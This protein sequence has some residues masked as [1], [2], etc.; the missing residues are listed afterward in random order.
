MSDASPANHFHAKAI[1]DPT[2][3]SL[4]LAQ[5]RNFF[6]ATVSVLHNSSTTYRGKPLNGLAS[7]RA[8]RNLIAFCPA[9]ILVVIYPLVYH[10][11]GL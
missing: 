1:S 11:L 9:F 10:A 6:Y 5:D 3:S 4:Q 8:A 7:T 2:F